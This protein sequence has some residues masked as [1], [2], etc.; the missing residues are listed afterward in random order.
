MRLPP[1]ESRLVTR[2]T[3]RLN[4][5]PVL[6]Y[7]RATV[8]SLALSKGTAQKGSCTFIVDTIIL[9]IRLAGSG[10]LSSCLLSETSE[11]YSTLLASR[12]SLVHA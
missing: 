3:P 10:L 1:I 4:A 2:V 5:V 8:S 9:P 6:I 7:S 12:S 11:P